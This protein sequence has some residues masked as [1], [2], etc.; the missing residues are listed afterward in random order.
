MDTLKQIVL[1]SKTFTVTAVGN[2]IH[3]TEESWKVSK[4]LSLG[5]YMLKWV[6]R[7]LEGCA[8]C[9]KK[10][11]YASLRDGNRSFIAQ[12][13]SNVHGHFME[14]VEYGVGGRQSFFIH[15]GRKGR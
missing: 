8:S 5:L 10:E 1:E 2:F 13:C 6:I 4:E 12:R 14:L 9:D 3:I 11:F 7:L 15:A